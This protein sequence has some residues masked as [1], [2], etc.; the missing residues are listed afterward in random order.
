MLEELLDRFKQVA[1]RAGVRAVYGDPVHAHGR[2]F[3]PVA[4]VT[5]GF[6]IGGGRRQRHEQEEGQ[7]EE[8]EQDEGGGGGAGLAA[9]P[10][11]VVEI[12]DDRTRVIPVWDGNRL[13]L[14]GLL[15]L[16]WTVFWLS[17]RRPS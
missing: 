17:R 4:R 3:V 15:F 9:R 11:A 1:E 14:A 7:E 10:V 2:T 5:Y 8:R 12:R 13:V 16:A 6:G